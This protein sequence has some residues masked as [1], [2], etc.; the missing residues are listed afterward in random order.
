MKQG[1]NMEQWP[2]DAPW[3]RTRT[4]KDDSWMAFF[5]YLCLPPH[6]RSITAA[7]RQFSG[8]GPETKVPNRWHV[9]ARHHHWQERVVEYERWHRS[10]EQLAAE[11][12]KAD[13][14]ARWDEIRTNERERGLN[15]GRALLEKAQAMLQFPLA[16]VVRTTEVYDDGREKEVQVFKPAGWNFGTV[17]RMIEVGSKLVQ[18]M[19]ELD[20]ER[21]RIDLTTIYNEADKV[22]AEIGGGVTRD[23]V[24]AMAERIVLEHEERAREE[25]RD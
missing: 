6:E 14:A 16:E 13:E 7:Y 18:L 4:E 24:L 23:D 10:R 9:W 8:E 11:R 5:T 22:A 19:A 25:G 20:T 1:A 3:R 12:A 2:D 21:H 17:A 15:I